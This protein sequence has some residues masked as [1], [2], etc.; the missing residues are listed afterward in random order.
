LTRGK[1]RIKA[2]AKPNL[3]GAFPYNHRKLGM[4]PKTTQDIQV[5]GNFSNVRDNS[6]NILQGL[7]LRRGDLLKINHNLNTECF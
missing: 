3:V 1:A 5:L 2:A 7:T 4:E 6:I